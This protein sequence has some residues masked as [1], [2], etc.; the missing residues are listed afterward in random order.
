MNE[1]MRKGK[2]DTREER[3]NMTTNERKKERR[4]NGMRE[5]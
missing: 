3:R 2:T 5:K 4:K 1:A